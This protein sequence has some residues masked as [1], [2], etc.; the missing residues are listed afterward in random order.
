MGQCEVWRSKFLASSLMVEELARWKASL[1][2]KNNTL[3]AANSKMLETTAKAKEIN[4]EVMKNLLYLCQQN[5][6]KLQSANLLD[7]SSECLNLSQQMTLN[8]DGIGMPNTNLNQLKNLEQ[9]TEAEKMAVE[10][11]QTNNRPLQDTELA[12][13]AVM[14]QAFHRTSREASVPPSE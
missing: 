12:Y 11:L 6:V 13:R 14:D 10:A 5:D 1:T 2:Q 9:L 8:S 7:I 4:T 3:T